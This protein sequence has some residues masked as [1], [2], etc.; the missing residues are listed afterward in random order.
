MRSESLRGRVDEAEG[1]N[2]FAQLGEPYSLRMSDVME[3]GRWGCLE[4][5]GVVTVGDAMLHTRASMLA[6]PQV[7]KKTTFRVMEVMERLGLEWP[8]FG[9]V[10]G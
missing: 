6:I 4:R 3:Y 2:F 1:A 7:G 10:E 5:A 9:E 8:V